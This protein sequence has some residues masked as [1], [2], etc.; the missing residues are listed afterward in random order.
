MS[1]PPTAAQRQAVR[2]A[3]HWYARLAAGGTDAGEQASWQTWHDASEL[4]RQAWQRM[5]TVTQAMGGLPQRLASAT[6]LG[7]GNTRRQVLYGLALMLGAGSLGTLAWRSDKRREWAADYRSGVGERRE[8]QLADGSQL[9]L[10]TDS[11]V[12]V[13]FDPQQRLLVLRRGQVLISTASDSA[14]RPFRVDT[15]HGRVLALGTRFTVSTDDRHSEVAVLEKAVQVSVAQAPAVRLQAGQRITFGPA[16]IGDAASNDASVAAWRNG[17]LI[18]ID[19]PLGELVAQLSRYRP[20]ILRCDPA[21]AGLKVSGAFPTAD[22]DLALA[23]LQDGF[24]VQVV[25]RTRYWVTVVAR[26]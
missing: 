13:Q 4:H 10:D 9:L 3:A 5:Q 20:G 6:L 25:A 7:A 22:T 8:V 15:H 24:P 2:E 19:Q 17:S 21:V 1:Q 12:D 26:P 11:A 18:A 16:G 14:G 23:A